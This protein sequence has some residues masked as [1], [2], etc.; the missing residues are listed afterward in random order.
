MHHS[1]AKQFMPQFM[2]QLDVNVSP[3]YLQEK[4]SPGEN[5]YNFRMALW[6]LLP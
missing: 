1:Q 2:Q 4:S 3:T 5:V 6:L